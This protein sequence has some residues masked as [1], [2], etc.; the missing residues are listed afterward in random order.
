MVY[1]HITVTY[2]IVLAPLRTFSK[3]EKSQ[4]ENQSAHNPMLTVAK[5]APA[6]KN[7]GTLVM[8]FIFQVFYIAPKPFIWIYITDGRLLN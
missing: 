3:T 5:K 7:R 8:A 4:H 6:M 1:M 2:N